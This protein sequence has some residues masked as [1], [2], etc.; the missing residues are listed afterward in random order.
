[1]QSTIKKLNIKVV[2]VA[3]IM[4]IN[5]NSACTESH[6][7]TPPEIDWSFNGVFGVFKRDQLQRGFQV[8]KE[9]CSVCHGI[10]LVR[11]EKLAA[12][13]F[14]KAEIK[15]IAAEAEVPG[16]LDNDGEPT[17]RKGIPGDHFA[18]PYP[19]SNAARAANNGAFPPDLALMAKA[20][21]N[22]TDYIYAILDGYELAP[23][24]F[25]LMD[26]MY[27]NPYF[28]GNQIAMPPPLSDNIV[29][30]SDGTTASTKQMAE[31]V[32]AFLAWTAEPELEAR[33]QLGIKV[34]I[35]LSFFTILMYCMMRRTWR[36][37]KG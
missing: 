37:I 24:D 35:Y 23:D 26:G 13:G 21:K 20:R 8:Y 15:A 31:D 32:A 12:L 3:L 36:K 6:V 33:R 2:L 5:A 27:Y 18:P 14:S 7:K 22:G 30:Y 4:V 11:Y 17:K 16:P 25:G 29:T 9:V 34:L 19:N 10:E 28:D 1:M